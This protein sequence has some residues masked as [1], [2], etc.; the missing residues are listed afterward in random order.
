MATPNPISIGSY[1]PIDNIPQYEKGDKKIEIASMDELLACKELQKG[2]ICHLYYGNDEI[3]ID[4]LAGSEKTAL[5]GTITGKTTQGKT[6]YVVRKIGDPTSLLYSTKEL[7]LLFKKITRTP[8]F[9]KLDPVPAYINTEESIYLSGVKTGKKDD[10]IAIKEQLNSLNDAHLQEIRKTYYLEGGILWNSRKRPLRLY[11]KHIKTQEYKKISFVEK[12]GPVS[13]LWINDIVSENITQK[14]EKKA[15]ELDDLIKNKKDELVRLGNDKVLYE[16]HDNAA[17][18]TCA[19][20]SGK[21]QST[22]EAN[23]QTAYDDVKDKITILETNKSRG[24]AYL[25]EV[26]KFGD[27]ISIDDFKKEYILIMSPQSWTLP[28]AQAVAPQVPGATVPGTVVPQ[29]KFLGLFGGRRRTKRNNKKS[30]KQGKSKKQNKS[31]RLFSGFL[32]K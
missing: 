23:A 20:F 22:L 9:S 4:E 6:T 32:F 21:D 26:L 7:K 17:S 8:L 29:E 16:N 3:Y 1:L 18:K 27:K 10:N 25:D 14:R 28:G 24:N 31:R 30:Q 15:K 13:N 12:V 11:A 2:K 5:F 19:A